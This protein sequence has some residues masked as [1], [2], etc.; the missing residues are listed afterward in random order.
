MADVDGERG[1]DR[2]VRRLWFK[3]GVCLLVTVLVAGLL[4]MAPPR[5]SQV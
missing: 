4:V 1:Q 2:R 5:W 3:T